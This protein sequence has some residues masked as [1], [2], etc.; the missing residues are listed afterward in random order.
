MINGQTSKRGKDM[1]ADIVSQ[2]SFG[3]LG[4]AIV[5]RMHVEKVKGKRGERVRKQGEGTKW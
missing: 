1:S 2:I 5:R 4:D 3:A